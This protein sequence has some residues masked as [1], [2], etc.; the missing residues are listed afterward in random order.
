MSQT[1]ADHLVDTEPPRKHHVCPWWVGYLLLIPLRKLSENPQTILA[2]LARPG[3]T[4]IDIGCAMGYFSLPLARM[5]GDSGRVVCVDL[6]QRML[7]ALSRRARRQGL[8]RI[9]ETRLCTQ[10]TLGL[11]DLAGQADLV[12]AVHV[13][14]EAAH[15]RSFLAQCYEVLRPGGTLLLVEPKGHVS[16]AE[17]ASTRELATDLGFSVASNAATRRS[18]S[19]VLEKRDGRDTEGTPAPAHRQSPA[20]SP[21]PTSDERT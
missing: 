3:M 20:A 4:A 15:P 12:L 8:D 18:W 11:G 2:P 7:T 21:Y 17:L 9:I 13:V 6:Q 1:T 10:A 19:L 14:H 5:V 16:S